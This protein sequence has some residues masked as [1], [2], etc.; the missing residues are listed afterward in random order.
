MKSFACLSSVRAACQHTAACLPHG[1]PLARAAA[2]APL[3]ALGRSATG[4]DSVGVRSAV[5]QQPL[6]GARVN[7]AAA[8]VVVRHVSAAAARP[9]VA[10]GR[11]DHEVAVYRLGGCVGAVP[12]PSQYSPYSKA[13]GRVD[14]KSLF[15]GDVIPELCSRLAGLPSSD[16]TEG[17]ATLLGAC[18]EYGLDSQSPLVRIL[19]DESLQ[20]LGRHGGDVGLAQLCHL[21]EVAHALE[22]R[23]SAV[24]AGVL[25]SV[26]FAVAEGALGP[27]EAVTVY[28]LLALCHDPASRRQSHTLSALHRQTQRLVHRLRAGQVSDILQ[29][30]VKFQQRQ[31]GRAPLGGF[32]LRCAGRQSWSVNVNP[33]PVRFSSGHLPGAQ[34]ESQ[35]LTALQ[36][37]QR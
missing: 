7:A 8:V 28:S 2:A 11:R 24:L 27:G 14:V 36:S 3:T 32:E 34:A 10:P 23:S 21:G 22:G 12:Q 9:S 30:L 16:R 26:G 18:A 15:E 29:L 25:N 5:V 13:R 4:G 20:L 17:L 31:V 33:I 19:M 1:L 6:H 35:G 37:L